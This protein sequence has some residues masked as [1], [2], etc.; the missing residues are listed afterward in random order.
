MGKASRWNMLCLILIGVAWLTSGYLLLR[1]IQLKGTTSLDVCAVLGSSCDQTLGKSSSW[2]LGFPLAAWGLVY[3]ALLGLLIALA[4]PKILRAAR[5]LAAAGAGASLV[6]LLV[7]FM[8]AAHLCVLCLF[9][10]IL[11]LS[12]FLA[13]GQLCGALPT[14]DS[15]PRPATKKRR[16]PTIVALV[17][18]TVCQATLMLVGNAAARLDGEAIL[19]DYHASEK[20]QIPVD[21]TDPILGSNHD[22]PAR[23]VVFSS[24]QCPACQRF[25]QQTRYIK[26]HFGDQVSIV[27]KHFPLSSECNPIVPSDFQPGACAVSRAAEAARQQGGFWAFHD[28]FYTSNLSGIGE[29][30]QSIAASIDLDVD[31]WRTDCDTSDTRAK[32][33][34]DVKLGAQLGVNQTPVI[35]LNG[36]RVPTVNLIGVA[37]LIKHEVDAASAMATKSV[38][39]AGEKVR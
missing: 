14:V 12:L 29:K 36:R 1:L 27:F 25:G 28:A 22:A 16:Y 4:N 9:V 7:L 33:E 8:D 37:L 35:F 39:D 13:I 34:R 5:L 6:L 17:V 24:F 38:V 23:L 3:F 10:Q 11:N 32:I 30:V 2:Q 20:H 19:A 26:E 21:P 31:L 15:I 18:G